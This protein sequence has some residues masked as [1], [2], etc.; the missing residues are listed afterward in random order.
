M[1]E[2]FDQSELKENKLQAVIGGTD[3]DEGIILDP[4]KIAD[5]QKSCWE[6]N[7]NQYDADR[8]SKCKRLG[9]MSK[10]ICALMLQK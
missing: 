10:S 3:E 5:Y 6:K 9:D 2:K 7:N 1:N 8:C 4:Q